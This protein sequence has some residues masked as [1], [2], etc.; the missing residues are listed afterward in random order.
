MTFKRRVLSA[1]GR[2]YLLGIGRGLELE[3]AATDELLDAIAR[4]KRASIEIP[5][6][7]T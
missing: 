1:L 7:A 3:V 2:D 5:M 6:D 4:S